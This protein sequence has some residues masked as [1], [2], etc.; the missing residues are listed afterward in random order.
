MI[1]DLK[2]IL[3]PI[4]FS[5]HSF[6]ALRGAHELARDVGAEM[7]LLHVVA[8]HHIFVPLPLTQDVEKTRE[9]AREAA[10]VEQAEEELGR[11]KRDQLE[12]SPKVVTAVTVGTPVAK[13]LEYVS[14]H[15]I[16][17][18]VLSTHGRSGF[19][20]VLIGSV[21]ERLVRNAPC[22]VLV[23]RAPAQT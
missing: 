3:A 14:E 20:G 9:M 23:L 5:E 1:Q 6:Q 12:N 13:I 18:L 4:D 10:M 8:P 17:L 16:D 19:Q 2:K 7:H 21:T 11:I 15:D 22:S